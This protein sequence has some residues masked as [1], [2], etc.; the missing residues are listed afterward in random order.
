MK[1][2]MASRSRIPLPVAATII[3]LGVVV[4][5]V[6]LAYYGMNEWL[7]PALRQMRVAQ[8]RVMLTPRARATAKPATAADNRPWTRSY[9]DPTLDEIAAY[10]GG[11]RHFID[12]QD[13]AAL[14]EMADK[15][16][17][18]KIR[19]GNG[20]WQ[21]YQFYKSFEPA[22][23]DRGGWEKRQ[24]TLE[25]WKA[26]SPKSVTARIALAEFLTG[27]AWEARG[28]GWGN[29]VSADAWKLFRKRLEDAW[30]E[31]DAAGDFPE[32]DPHWYSV[33]LTVALG[34]QWSGFEAEQMFNRAVAF[35]PEYVAYYNQRAKFL[36]PRWYGKEGDWEAFAAAVAAKPGGAE[37]YARIVIEM[38]GYHE[39]IFKETR[40]TWA[41]AKPGVVALVA[42]YP[43]SPDILSQAA[44]LAC[45]GNDRELA[46]EMFTKLG[47]RIDQREW[48][49]AARYEYFQ[50]YAFR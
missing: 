4:G 6:A 42:H 2:G 50:K 14:E 20:S 17:T 37:L 48:K 9:R 18:E 5:V 8:S 35:Q 41:Q 15:A 32:K 29:T 22:K 47:D 33:A 39:Q 12:A 44:R 26:H 34:Q 24:Q 21:I 45:L 36:M 40:A 43:E 49:T 28:S 10:R 23:S 38:S 25:A 1:E 46:R 30:T 7:L 31:L 16:R 27:Y 19:F 13:F 3:V 11:V